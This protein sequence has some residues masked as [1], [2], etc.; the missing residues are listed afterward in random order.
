MQVTVPMNPVMYPSDHEREGMIPPWKQGNDMTNEIPEW[1]IDGLDA[2]MRFLLVPIALLSI[3]LLAVGLHA[4]S[5]KPKSPKFHFTLNQVQA[6]C[7]AGNETFT[8]GS[9]PEGY[10]CAGA[11][12][13]LSCTAKGN[14]TFTPKLGGPKI[15]RNTTIENL[16]RGEAGAAG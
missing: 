8:P 5:A 1:D 13:T 4:A 11:G 9:G 16:I 7:I 2:V 10:G 15:V 3:L 12:G 14:C 6:S